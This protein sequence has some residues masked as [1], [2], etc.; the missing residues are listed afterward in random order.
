MMNKIESFSKSISTKDREVTIMKSKFDSMTEEVEKKKKVMDDIRNE[1][2]QEKEKLNEKI[3]QLRQKN[4]EVSD[5]FIQ[6]KLEDAR[7]LALYKQKME[8][9]Q[10]RID[11]MQKQLEEIG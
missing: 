6:K 9:Q 10:K 3:E 7:E 5:E 1:Y 4:Q 2:A 8:F 11:E